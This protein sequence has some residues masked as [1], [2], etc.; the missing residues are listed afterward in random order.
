MVAGIS[1]KKREDARALARLKTGDLV[2]TGQRTLFLKNLAS[3]LFENRLSRGLMLEAV[4]EQCRECCENGVAWATSQAGRKKLKSIT[5]DATFRK[6]RVNPVYLRQSKGLIVT[7][8]A[9]AKRIRM[10]ALRVAQ[11]K[12]FPDSIPAVEVYRRLGLEKETRAAQCQVSRDM[13]SAGF[14][15]RRVNG[16]WV[17]QRATGK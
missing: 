8:G 11:I 2:P 15:S 17:W 4:T 14:A 7:E 16:Q 3:R 5:N 9:D 6:K 12:R 10:T 1:T 13:K